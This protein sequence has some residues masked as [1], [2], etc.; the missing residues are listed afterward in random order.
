MC[1]RTHIALQ[2]LSTQHVLAKLEHSFITPQAQ[3]ME[4]KQCPHNSNTAWMDGCLTSAALLASH[5]ISSQTNYY[6]SFVIANL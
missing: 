3:M 4:L 1:N 2:H 6:Y 5:L